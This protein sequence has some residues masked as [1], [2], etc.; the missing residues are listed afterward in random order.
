MQG[1]VE[2]FVNCTGRMT[3]Y[4]MIFPC[5]T[6]FLPEVAGCRVRTMHKPYYT[7]HQT[8]VSPQSRVSKRRGLGG[9]WRLRRPDERVTVSKPKTGTLFASPANRT[10]DQ[11]F[12]L[13]SSCGVPE[14]LRIGDSTG[15]RVLFAECLVGCCLFVRPSD[16][17]VGRSFLTD[18]G[19]GSAVVLFFGWLVCSDDAVRGGRYPRFGRMVPS[20]P[21]CRSVGRRPRTGRVVVLRCRCRLAFI[22]AHIARKM[23][24][25]PPRKARASLKAGNFWRPLFSPP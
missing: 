17:S 3:F 23:I 4:I 7:S 14:K 2:G 9:R 8:T 12:V 22:Y 6:Y 1:C 15:M 10:V 13:L 16:R 11:P 25:A 20:V 5:T 24:D 18:G 19:E 21:V